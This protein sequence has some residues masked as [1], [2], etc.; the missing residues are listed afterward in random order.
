M[1][2]PTQSSDIN[3]RQFLEGTVGTDAPFLE[4]QT[5]FRNCAKTP[6]AAIAAFG[7]F[8][9]ALREDLGELR[10]V[11]K[12]YGLFWAIAKPLAF[13]EVLQQVLLRTR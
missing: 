7:P 8:R 11:A 12:R 13:A 4:F 9:F 6:L 2:S 1:T 3:R 10:G 5:E